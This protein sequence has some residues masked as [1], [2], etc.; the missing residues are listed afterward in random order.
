MGTE[1][2][3]HAEEARESAPVTDKGSTALA[4]LNAMRDSLQEAG[5]TLLK[6]ATAVISAAANEVNAATRVVIQTADETLNA[7]QEKIRKLREELLKR[8]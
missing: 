3:V 8:D 6:A 5:L 4:D 1:G 2:A 7:A